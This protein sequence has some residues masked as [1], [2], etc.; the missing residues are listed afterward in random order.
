MWRQLFL[1]LS[2]ATH[3][4]N[5]LWQTYSLII[6]LL[7]LTF[8]RLFYPSLLLYCLSCRLISFLVDFRILKVKMANSGQGS[9]KHSGNSHV[10]LNERILSSMSRRSFAAHPW[11]DLE[12]GTV[13][14]SFIYEILLLAN[15]YVR[16]IVIF[17][18]CGIYFYNIPILWPIWF[19]VGY[20]SPWK[21]K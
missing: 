19:E 18:F 9:E 15:H 5:F 16:I 10:L 17:I 7:D 2:N 14:F 21:V 12:I 11:H 3:W 8:K 20:F 6:C 4:V 1:F 13:Y